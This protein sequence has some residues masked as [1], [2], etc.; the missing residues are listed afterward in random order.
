MV[1]KYLE[2]TFDEQPLTCKA[3]HWQDIGQRANVIDFYGVSSH[4]EIHCPQCDELIGILEKD[5]GRP[6]GESAGELS[7]QFG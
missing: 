7:F 6:P 2:S 1:P 4:K 5:E 3:C